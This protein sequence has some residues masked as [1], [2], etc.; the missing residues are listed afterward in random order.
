[1]S[2][3]PVCKQEVK[4][5]AGKILF[6]IEKPYLNILFHK[7]CTRN[8]VSLQDYVIS[9]FTEIMEIYKGKKVNFD[10]K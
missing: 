4:W 5:G 3:C 2:I 1:M 10:R 8:I 7:D 9:N 6:P